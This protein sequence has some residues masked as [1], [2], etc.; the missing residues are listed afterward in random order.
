MC[1]LK[2]KYNLGVYNSEIQ[3]KRETFDDIASKPF[4]HITP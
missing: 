1:H 4:F 2:M 3:K